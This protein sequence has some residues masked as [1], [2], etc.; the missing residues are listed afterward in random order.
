MPHQHGIAG[1]VG[2]FDDAAGGAQAVARGAGLDYVEIYAS[3]G[4]GF[5]GYAV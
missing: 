3:A 1:K 2:F 5:G 4:A